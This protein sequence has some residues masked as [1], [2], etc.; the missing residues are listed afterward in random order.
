[1]GREEKKKLIINNQNMYVIS[2]C[3]ADAK[4]MPREYSI[5]EYSIDKKE[6][7]FL[8]PSLKEISDYC[9][10]RKNN[11]DP[12][13]FLSFYESKGWKI[14]NQ[15]MKDWQAAVRTWEKRDKSP[16]IFNV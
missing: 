14:G 2:D 4:P 7:R 15:P 8:K 16:Q 9:E 12:E 13:Q 11:I 1:M 6:R 10:E 3:L 5:E